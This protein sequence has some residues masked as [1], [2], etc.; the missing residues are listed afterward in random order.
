MI[1]HLTCKL[2][3]LLNILLMWN[4]SNNAQ[5]V[6]VESR[7]NTH[8]IINENVC[9]DQSQT[10]S[11]QKNR[12]IS[13]DGYTL[14]IQA[15]YEMKMIWMMNNYK[16]D[17]FKVAAGRE[18]SFYNLQ[19]G[20]YQILSLYY[21]LKIDNRYFMTLFYKELELAGND[22]LKI[23]YADADKEKVFKLKRIDNSPLLMST[24]GF[25]FYNS[26]LPGGISYTR[27]DLNY[28]LPVLKEEFTL[29]YNKF[30]NEPFEN[31]W[32][33]IGK[34]PINKGDFYILNG[35][36]TNSN[37]DSIIENYPEN[38]SHANFRYN[39][40]DTAV[41]STPHVAFFPGIHSYLDDPPYGLPLE[42]RVYQ[43]TSANI[44][45]SYSKFYNQIDLKGDGGEDLATINMRLA[46]DKVYGFTSNEG[47]QEPIILSESENVTFG[48]TP[49]YWFG[50]YENTDNKIQIRSSWGS[51]NAIQLFLS[52]TND[53]LPQYP[54]E[55]KIMAEDSLVVDKEILGV[56][57]RDYPSMGYD[58]DSLIYPV[59]SGKY[60]VTV[61]ND[62][63]EVAKRAASTI[64]IADFDLGEPDKNPPYM[65]L[66]QILAAKNLTN[67]LNSEEINTI[68]FSM[69]DDNRLN[70]VQ[71]FYKAEDDSSWSESHL[72]FED[73]LYKGELPL[74][75]GGFYSLKIAASDI[76]NNNL[77]VIMEPAFLYTNTTSADDHIPND[78][79]EYY[80]FN[81]Y[82]NP[83]NPV[84]VISYNLPEP[85]F[86][87]LKVYDVLGREVVRLVSEEQSS[88][89][90]K[91]N[92]D[93]SNLP[94]SRQ[95]I[96]S[97]VYYVTINTKTHNK[98]IKI[99]LLK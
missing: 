9:L 86:V 99:M 93:G 51:S 38:Y 72:T 44:E 19:K 30:P 68:R 40:P 21:Y 26:S 7:P 50:K 52:Q 83:F 95:G 64:S 23:N 62:K 70:W 61:T 66:F 76:S 2:L 69:E 79:S 1:E 74:L 73:S 35:D 67:R 78:K 22:T 59:N 98:T 5:S 63:S 57:Y 56:V 18:Y 43:D 84:T 6:S 53:A 31:E 37:T 27:L 4:I 87:T 55:I 12:A 33:V 54:N 14:V 47:K 24:I 88:G 77:N 8:I 65:T 32:R 90:H 16:E 60:R 91:V 75:P 29:K 13:S 42:L 92:F 3:I 96:Q 20:T 10:S 71:L 11:T 25:S 48:L 94:Y 58:P 80:L 49:T 41:A 17:F 28:R 45:L 15:D 89:I 85:S 97:G 81:N 46:K 34:Q 82:P 36:F 39:F